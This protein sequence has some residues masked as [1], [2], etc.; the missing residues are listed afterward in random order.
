MGTQRE[1]RGRGEFREVRAARALSSGP[2]DHP[3]G[4]EAGGAGGSRGGCAQHGCSARGPVIT[5]RRGAEGSRRGNMCAH[6]ADSLTPRGKAI[7]L[8]LT[9]GRKG[10][11]EPLLFVARSK[12]L[13]K[14]VLDGNAPF[15]EIAEN[16]GFPSV[17]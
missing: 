12:P 10:G 3:G 13:P 9:K 5:Q 4:G 16:T 2:R 6:M 17:S 1:R 7:I 15:A 8:Q 14:C 11:G